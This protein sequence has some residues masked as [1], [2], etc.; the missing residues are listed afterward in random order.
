[1]TPPLHVTFFCLVFFGVPR[2][3]A[4][5][6][7]AP[8]APGLGAARHHVGGGAPA[9]PPS[10]CR[11]SSS[12]SL[13]SQRGP[14]SGPSQDGTEEGD[15]ATDE[16]E[17][18][19]APIEIPGAAK[20]RETQKATAGG[21]SD[22]AVDAAASDDD[23]EAAASDAA[24][25]LKA[26]AAA[27]A[28]AE[29]AAK[30]RRAALSI[31]ND[32]K[33]AEL[34]GDW[35]A[36]R[37]RVMT[38]G[39]P[40]QGKPQTVA[41]ERRFAATVERQRRLEAHAEQQR[42]AA[43]AMERRRREE[44]AQDAA[45]GRPRRRRPSSKTSNKHKTKT[46]TPPPEPK[47]PSELELIRK[48]ALAEEMLAAPPKAAEGQ[49]PH[50]ALKAALTEARDLGTMKSV[51]LPLP[52]GPDPGNL[53]VTRVQQPSLADEVERS[54]W[55]RDMDDHIEVGTV[56]VRMPFECELLAQKES[57]WH[58]RLQKWLRKIRRRE[59]DEVD[60]MV[61]L[62]MIAADREAEERAENDRAG[63]DGERLRRA[64]WEPEPPETKPFYDDLHA[65]RYATRFIALEMERI[66]NKGS[67]DASGRLVVD[68]KVL[69]EN[70]KLFLDARQKS[71]AAW[72]EAVLIV[73]HDANG[74]HG[75]C[76]NR[77]AATKANP[78]LGAA[79]AAAVARDEI[80]QWSEREY[81]REKK[82]AEH[83]GR[84][85]DVETNILVD[86]HLEEGLDITEAMDRLAELRRSDA[87]TMRKY[88]EANTALEPTEHT[89]SVVKKR[90][91]GAAADDDDDGSAWAH[92]RPEPAPPAV[93]P[94]L[95]H[96]AFSGNFGAYV[97]CS[98]RAN[99][100]GNAASQDRAMLIHG[101][102][103]CAGAQELAPG[104]GIYRGGAAAAVEGIL[105]GT[106]SPLDF[107][108]FL[109]AYD[110]RPGELQMLIKEGSYRAVACSRS[111]V[112]KQ[113]LEMPYPY[114]NELLDMCG[115]RCAEI[116]QLEN[117]KRV[118]ADRLQR[119]KR[120]E[121]VDPVLGPGGPLEPPKGGWVTK[122]DDQN[123][124]GGG[125]GGGRPKQEDD[126]SSDG[127][128][129]AP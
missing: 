71:M 44:D 62:D 17:P 18:A 29:A 124:K 53:N 58:Q 49:S 30:A 91:D 117:K 16:T 102:D 104:L 99:A 72:Q 7:V 111:M 61:K 105:D 32:D 65:Y 22:A 51:V 98:D 113:C 27:E 95:F 35:R 1:M 106:K 75:V 24:S 109:G 114:W 86:L 36:F 118:D 97:G 45:A 80:A 108:I 115:G 25:A 101:H 9:A 69:S 120:G 122:K 60:P 37:A 119:M 77:P 12:T 74:T 85:E 5:F 43:E 15:G 52:K 59:W 128:G 92:G 42:R 121:R 79:I 26:A 23:P 57:F 66:S 54:S 63:P 129:T 40:I 31:E 90:P 103:D 96:R 8:R 123:S 10:L 2:L 67:L 34:T 89:V 56:V 112:L 50:E 127:D 19:E 82:E 33:A 47:P 68:P 87:E 38:E 78:R 70:D 48:Q 4:A 20:R 116:S 84:V 14:S 41:E 21:E 76:L 28:K 126:G 81:L 93:D 73:K 55:A 88:A 3:A 100:G 107:R 39:L 46:P 125:A 11:T 13:A 83:W 6:H 110:W 94:G 64:P